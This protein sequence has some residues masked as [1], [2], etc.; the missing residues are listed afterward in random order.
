VSR[1]R[2]RFFSTRRRTAYFLQI[3]A[4]AAAPVTGYL[5]EG[6]RWWIA[7]SIVAAG[8]A[9]ALGEARKRAS[10]ELAAAATA[11]EVQARIDA[12]VAMVATLQPMATT[13]AGV[14]GSSKA[15]R[16]SMRGTVTQAVVVAAVRQVSADDVRGA[17]YAH[18]IVSGRRVLRRTCSDGRNDTTEHTLFEAGTVEGDA[19]LEMVDTD[20]HLYVTDIGSDPPAGWDPHRVRRYQTFIAVGISA[21]GRPLGML[22][23]DALEPGSLTDEDLQTVILLAS[24]LRIGLVADL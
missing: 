14:V 9:V 24:L 20:D 13:L 23:V 16:Q 7:G 2:R 1:T 15:S 3:V 21:Q 8:G 6:S 19:A 22:T 4:A 11:D 5:I 18:E 17:W 12:R 10:E